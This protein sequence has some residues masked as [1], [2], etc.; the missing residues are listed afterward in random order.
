MITAEQ[1]QKNNELFIKQSKEKWE[2]D[3]EKTLESIEKKL[4]DASMGGRTSCEILLMVDKS[5]YD[6]DT[7]KSYFESLGYV[8]SFS[9]LRNQQYGPVQIEQKIMELSWKK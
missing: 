3:H 6:E 7:Y 1:C 8:V 4:T 5:Q 9:T 2:K